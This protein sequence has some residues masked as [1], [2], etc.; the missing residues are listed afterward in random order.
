MRAWH[1]VVPSGL[2]VSAA[3]LFDVG[4]PLE[5]VLACWFLFACPALGYVRILH[6]A[7]T[8]LEIALIVGLGLAIDVAVSL[9]LVLA[10][11]YEPLLALA[12]ITAIAMIGALV[13]ARPEHVTPSTRA[14]PVGAISRR[15]SVI[16]GDEAARSSRSRSPSPASR[17]TR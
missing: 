15:R 2:A 11:V 16:D 17:E 6:L 5:I 10:G 9:I 3:V 12:L 7:D 8:E 14:S 13:D 1:V 4:G